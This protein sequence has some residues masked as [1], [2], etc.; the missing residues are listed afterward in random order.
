V[1]DLRTGAGRT[2]N[3]GNSQ[4]SGA[5]AAGASK[6]AGLTAVH[7]QADRV[8]PYSRL[9]AAA[10]RPF[11]VECDLWCDPPIRG[12]PRQLL[13]RLRRT[14][15][16]HWQWT[17]DLYQARDTVKFV[18]REA[19]FAS[20]MA[21]L[22]WRGIPQ[23]VTVHNLLPHEHAHAALHR[24]MF[25][26]M[27]ALADRLIVHHSDAIEPVAAL[28]GHR[29]KIRV[30]PMM[31]YGEPLSRGSR[32][33][34]RQ[35]WGL[36]AKSRWAILFGAI[37]RYKRIELVL[38]AARQLEE[39]GIGLVVVGNCRDARYGGEIEALTRGRATVLIPGSLSDEELSELLSASDAT[40]ML[41]DAKSLTSSAAHLALS[42]GL[43]IVA[44]DALAFRDMARRGLVT[45]CNPEDT[46]DLVSAVARAVAMRTP[47]WLAKVRDYRRDCSLPVVGR[48]LAEIYADVAHGFDLEAAIPRATGS[49][50]M[51]P[52]D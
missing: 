20:V 30:V 23:V 49:N 28:Y 11:G 33:T 39:N 25:L 22:R 21:E 44:A 19:L 13:P 16:V 6:A 18:I 4:C 1:D 5:G 34:L 38:R 42:H 14:G 47:E 45:T 37:R 10:L 50:G 40:V 35:K 27:G 51:R 31:D 7:V 8:N 24:C 2:V 46:V 17:H 12:N 52:S 29:A 41:Y 26:T 15:L 9:L 43:P 3:V 48:R 36:E 32:E